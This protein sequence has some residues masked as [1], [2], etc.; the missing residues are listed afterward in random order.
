MEWMGWTGWMKWG[1]ECGGDR[2]RSYRT[3]VADMQMT[4]V[5]I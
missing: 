5:E 4:V 2:G 1:M 3:I